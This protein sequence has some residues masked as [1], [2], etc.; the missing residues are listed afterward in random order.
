ME[1]IFVVEILYDHDLTNK[2]KT[3]CNMQVRSYEP[4]VKTTLNLW[5]NS[6]LEYIIVFE[7]KTI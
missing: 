3:K 5:Q 1:D 2:K 4:F 6:R 7:S